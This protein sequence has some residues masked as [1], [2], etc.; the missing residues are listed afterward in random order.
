MSFSRRNYKRRKLPMSISK[1]FKNRKKERLQHQRVNGQRGWC[2]YLYYEHDAYKEN[3][4]QIKEFFIKENSTIEE[5]Q[6]ILKEEKNINAVC[7]RLSRIF[8]EKG[9]SIDDIIKSLPERDSIDT[10]TS[11]HKKV[12]DSLYNCNISSEIPNY[13]INFFI[14]SYFLGGGIWDKFYKEFK[15]YYN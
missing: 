11:Y 13:L 10:L 7:S 1:D 6:Q 9:I 3:Y 4:T 8:W 2:P 12:L 5:E 14:D 15:E